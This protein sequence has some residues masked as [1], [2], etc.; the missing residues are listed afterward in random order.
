MS[1]PPPASRELAR[2]RWR[3]RRGM[4]ELDQLL[5]RYLDLRYPDAGDAEKAAFAELL[6]LSDPELVGYL[7]QKQV[8]ESPQRARVVEQI[9]SLPVS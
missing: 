7:L 6:N 4:R 1:A 9:L 3:C 2:L 5:R 8:P